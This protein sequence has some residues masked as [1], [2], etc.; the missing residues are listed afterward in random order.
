MRTVDGLVAGLGSPA[1]DVELSGRCPAVG[2]DVGIGDVAEHSGLDGCP[3]AAA[4]VALRCCGHHSS[5]GAVGVNATGGRPV[6]G[7]CHAALASP[8]SVVA[9]HNHMNSAYSA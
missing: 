7:A 1:G 8:A 3:A 9:G 4:C 2:L 5:R 6:G